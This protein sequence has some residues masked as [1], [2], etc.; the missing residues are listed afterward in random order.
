M[1]PD[2]LFE[3]IVSFL[4]RAQ[5]EPAF[6]SYR[7]VSQCAYYSPRLSERENQRTAHEHDLR[8]ARITMSI[9]PA[10]AFCEMF[11]IVTKPSDAVV[12]GSVLVST[13][14]LQL[15]TVS[16]TQQRKSPPTIVKSKSSVVPVDAPVVSKVDYHAVES[17]DNIDPAAPV[18]N[19]DNL[20][21]LTSAPLQL[22]LPFDER[23]PDQDN[24][25]EATG[26]VTSSNA[27]SSVSKLDAFSSEIERRKQALRGKSRSSLSFRTPRTS[28]ESSLSP[29]GRLSPFNFPVVTED[30]LEYRR[31]DSLDTKAVLMLLGASMRR[32]AAL[33]GYQ[34]MLLTRG[35]LK[36]AGTYVVVGVRK[37]PLLQKSE[38]CLRGCG[39]GGDE[40]DLWVRLRRGEHKAGEEFRP[41]RKVL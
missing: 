34:V 2:L 1:Q 13:S 16:A 30:M 11:Q 3:Q 18:L 41:L 24:M 8:H 15:Q 10:A 17:T 29:T 35:D 39:N 28:S 38:F 26:S 22:Q 25:S 21:S 23:R 33:V 6:A 9:P 19:S 31:E 37:S 5:G 27:L 7:T 36:P 4:T 20:R 12:N 40:A 32:P 14:E